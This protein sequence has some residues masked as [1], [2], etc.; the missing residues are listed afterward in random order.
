MRTLGY[1]LTTTPKVPFNKKHP[2]TELDVLWCAPLTMGQS[3]SV[4]KTDIKISS[5]YFS[6]C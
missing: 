2:I 4:E 5:I 1:E 6:D 3:D